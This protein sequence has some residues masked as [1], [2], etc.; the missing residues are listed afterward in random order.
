M[1]ASG[2]GASHAHIHT[3]ASLPW[4]IFG[5][6]L[7]S[8]TFGN[9][10]ALCLQVIYDMVFPLAKLATCYLLSESPFLPEKAHLHFLMVGIRA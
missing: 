1:P 8:M 9:L 5:E 3:V 10:L 6:A 2:G 4:T 7:A